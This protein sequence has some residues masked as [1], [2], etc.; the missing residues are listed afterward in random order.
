MQEQ[1]KEN[2]IEPKPNDGSPTES[3]EALAT[4]P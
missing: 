1:M 3:S 4:K 2:S